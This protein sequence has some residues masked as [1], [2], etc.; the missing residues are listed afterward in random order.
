[1]PATQRVW[2]P[3][4]AGQSATVVALA[5]MLMLNLT[6][7]VLLVSGEWSASP[8]DDEPAFSDAWWQSDEQDSDPPARAG[9]DT[10]DEPLHSARSAIKPVNEPT[11]IKAGD[12]VVTGVWSGSTV[13]TKPSAANRHR[14]RASNA[15]AASKP[16]RASEQPPA[17]REERDEPQLEFFGVPI[18]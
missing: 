16:G 15:S 17:E 2:F 13:A 9:L 12:A 1:M 5:L 6:V 8:A 14:D 11:P 4:S 18:E 7:L 3:T 10:I